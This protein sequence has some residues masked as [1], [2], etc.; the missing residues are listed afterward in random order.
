MNE[1]FEN[2][3]DFLIKNNKWIFDGIGTAIVL[4]ILNIIHK[5]STRKEL[6]FDSIL[7]NLKNA[8][9]TSE[10]YI[11]SDFLELVNVKKILKR[12]YPDYKD[13]IVIQYG[14]SVRNNVLNPN[15]YDFIVLLLGH[16]T[17]GD[18][19]SF[20][21]GT[22]PEKL[23]PGMK[24][25]DVVFRDY[26]SFLFA[27]VSGMPYENSVIKNGKI[28]YGP[29]GYFL[30]LKR[31]ARNILI[32]RDFLLRRFENEKIS[33]EKQVWNSMK[34]AY[35]TYEIVRSAYYLVSSLLQRNKIRQMDEVIFHKDIAKIA[36][37]ANL[38]DDITDTEQRETFDLLVQS[39]KRRTI[40]KNDRMFLNNIED[41]IN[42]LLKT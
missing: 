29:K 33:I 19:H 26:S 15:D 7:D 30:W 14:S 17:Q 37:V 34:G 25:I 8:H 21:V 11:R 35:D 32:D 39:L 2:I 22:S 10:Q 13:F 31:I 3:K 1:L 41:I 4:F 16:N 18:L 9:N 28:V 42:A 27:L 40:P 20:E 5:R 24:E 38:K 6:S 12:H 23:I 36:L